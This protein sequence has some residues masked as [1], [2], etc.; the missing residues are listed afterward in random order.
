[1]LPYAPVHELLFDA[2]APGALVLTSGNRSS[3]PIAFEDDAARDRLAGLVDAFL[4]GERAIARRVDDSV[5]MDGPL[6]PVIVR[7]SRGYAPA[8]VAELPLDRPLLALGADLKNAITLVV[9]GTA[10][11]S[12]HIGDLDHHAAGAAFTRTI[13]DLLRMYGVDASQVIVAHDAH[14]GYRSTAVAQSLGCRHL[15]VQHHR[16]HVASV[17]AERGALDTPVIGVAFDGTGYGDDGTIWG[18]EF[19]A[20]SVGV[21]FARVAHLRPALLPGGDAAARF[22][23]QALAGFVEG[24]PDLC[25]LTAPP[26][27]L[28][29]R[30]TAARR[31]A[32]S[33][34]RT[35]G[36]TSIGRLFDAMAALLGFT[37]A[38]SFEGQA[39]MWLEQ[40]AR[41]GV[42]RTRLH[43]PVDDGVID[44]RPAIVETIRARRDGADPCDLACAFHQGLVGALV[45]LAVRLASAHGAEAIVVSGG[46]FQN[47]L[48]LRLMRE[49]LPSRLPLWT[50]REVPPNDGGISLGQAAI[51]ACRGDLRVRRE[52]A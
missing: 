26:F 14:P 42:A 19:F 47:M 27:Y 40:C 11:V 1:M 29:A 38:V 44:Y 4:I 17:L 9:D 43:L 33:G 8:A 10:F 22:P 52:R 15:P 39:A 34:L 45:E 20:G 48:L 6:G 7:R 25:D 49:S 18:G 2:G 31:L 21:G 16:A 28:P 36:T 37:R 32:A 5:V 51:A 35:F 13:E 24:L 30:F 23:A 50:N 41:R 46:V 3:E 12:Q